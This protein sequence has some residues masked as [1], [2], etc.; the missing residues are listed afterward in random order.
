MKQQAYP[1]FDAS[2]IP[3]DLCPIATKP[4]PMLP[5]D[6]RSMRPVVDRAKCVKCAVCWLFCPVQCVVEQAG[7]VRLQSEDLQ[8]LRHLRHRVPA[9]CHRDD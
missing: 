5:G 3:D 1:M 9:T 6:W 4:T 8:R 7:L 2:T